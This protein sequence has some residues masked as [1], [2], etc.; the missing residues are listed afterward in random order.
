MQIIPA[1]DI[2]GGKTVRLLRGD[3]E[4]QTTYD[5]DPIALARRYSDLNLKTLHVVDL[6]G[7]LDGA[8]KNK[9]LLEAMVAS[10]EA[11]VQIGGGLREAQ[12]IDG[13]FDAGVN[14]VVIGSLAV[15]DPTIVRQWFERYGA[16]RL[17]LALDVRLDASGQAMVATH[18]WTRTHSL[19]IQEVIAQYEQQHL[20][21]V[22]CTDIARD[23]ALSGPSL[24]L[25]RRLSL[26]FPKIALQA[27]GGVS[28]ID[29]LTALREVGVA[30][31]IT[32]RALLEGKITDEEITSF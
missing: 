19:T 7:A 32:G 31:A 17:V 6:D 8:P 26:E 16:D 1:I 12:H 10:T 29:D 13:L 3:Y 5:A 9:A 21:H 14:R 27:S 4:Q 18:G 24:E 22:L 23:G 11:D 28:R 15:L 25:Y 2:R 30:G 20:A